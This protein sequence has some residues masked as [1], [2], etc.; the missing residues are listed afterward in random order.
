MILR[1]RIA[2]L[3]QG[4]IEDEP[5]VL[6]KYS[7][8]TSIFER[9]PKVVVFPKDA[10]D[11]STL[12]KFVHDAK[13]R[14]E[15]LSIT[16]RSAGT[17]M[18]GGSLTDSISLV[19]TRHMN[20]IGRIAPNWVQTQPGAY[21]RDVEKSTLLQQGTIIPTYPASRELCAVG[22]M[23]GNNS[24]GELTLRYGKTND[25]VHELDVVLSDGSRT[26]FKPLTKEELDAKRQEQTFEGSIYRRIDNLIT[27]HREEIEQARPDV[28]KNSSGYALWNVWRQG[29]FDLT[30]LITGSQG[31]LAIVTD[32]K[33]GTIK[34]PKHR[35]MLVIFLSDLKTLPTIVQRVLKHKPESFESYDDQTF[36]LAVRFMPQILLHFGLIRAVK[37]GISFIPEVL[38]VLSGGVPKLVLMAEFAEETPEAAQ[39]AAEEARESLEDMH[40]RMKIAKSETAAAKYWTI[41]RESFALLRKNLRNLYAAP[42]IDDMVVHPA[43]YPKFL[44]ELNAI[45]REYD[46]LYTIAGHIGDANFHIIPLVS[47]AKPDTRRVILELEDKVYAL[48]TKYHGSITGEHNDGIVRTPYVS[49]MYGEKMYDLF[50]E[51][52]NIFDPLNILNPGKK[53]GGTKEDIRRSMITK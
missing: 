41:R 9:F 47:L 49:L 53:V 26:T 12:V 36:K 29:M 18:S 14:G 33:I 5:E 19:F 32:S 25:W 24:G 2:P 39:K 11:V 45:L 50:K 3:I 44:P 4:D 13:E 22:G 35:A 34:L 52:K 21:Y 46:L 1:E 37:L 40:L 20:N 23:V 48:V 6:K 15:N 8:D 10:H 16:A 7:R 28:T 42:F 38:M 31:T 51:V 43:D 27:S 17:D 30:Q